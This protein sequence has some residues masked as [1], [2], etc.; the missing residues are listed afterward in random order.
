MDAD[1]SKT[2]Q[3]LLTKQGMKFKLNT[4]VVSGDVSSES[5]DVNIEAAKGG[6]EETVSHHGPTSYQ[7]PVSNRL[8]A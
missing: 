5:I 1:V 3:K 7:F 2:M 8:A 4:K 6:Q